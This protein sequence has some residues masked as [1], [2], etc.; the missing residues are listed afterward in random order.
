MLSFTAPAKL[1]MIT[2]SRALTRSWAGVFLRRLASWSWVGPGP[3]DDAGTFLE[4][5]LVCFF[6]RFARPCHHIILRFLEHPRRP[7]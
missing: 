3:S 6:A 1:R 2:T 4:G 7:R 5:T